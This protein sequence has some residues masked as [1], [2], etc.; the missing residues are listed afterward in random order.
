MVHVKVTVTSEPA[1]RLTASHCSFVPAV[2]RL[3]S[4]P[5]RA[6]REAYCGHLEMQRLCQRDCIGSGRAVVFASPLC[7]QITQKRRVETAWQRVRCSEC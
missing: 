1:D 3:G 7:A 6:A 2:L 5:R 4:W